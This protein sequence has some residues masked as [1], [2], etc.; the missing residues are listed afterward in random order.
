M[1]VCMKQLQ[2]AQRF[3]SGIREL[4]TYANFVEKQAAGV[5]KSLEKMS[6]VSPGEA[7]GI[8]GAIDPQVW[9][10]SHVEGFR[11]LLASKTKAVVADNGTDRD[12]LLFD[13][14]A[15]AAK[16]T[17]R[18]ATEGSKATIIALAYWTQLCQGMTAKEKYNL[19]LQKKPVV[20]KY[21][22]VPPSSTTILELPV[23]WKDLPSEVAQSVFP[24]GKPM[25]RKEFAADVMQFV[26]NMPLRKDHKLLQGEADIAAGSLSSGSASSG[27]SVDAICKVVEACSRGMQN[28]G[29]QQVL[30]LSSPVTCPVPAQ[31]E[32][33]AVEDGLVEEKTPTGCLPKKP[34]QDEQKD[35]EMSVEQQLEALQ[36]NARLLEE[37]ALKRPAS[38]KGLKRPAAAIGTV[39]Y[40]AICASSGAEEGTA[41]AQA[42]FPQRMSEVSAEVVVYA[43][44]LGRAMAP[45][46]KTE[47]TPREGDGS[48][49]SYIT[50]EEATWPEPAAEPPTRGG[51][52]RMTASKSKAVKKEKDERSSSDRGLRARPR[53][54][55]SPFSP[56]R[57]SSPRRARREGRSRDRS[58]K[59]ARSVAPEAARSPKRTRSVAAADARSPKRARSELPAAAPRSALD[60]PLS[61]YGKDFGKA[62]DLSLLPRGSGTDCPRICIEPAPVVQRVLHSLPAV[63]ERREGETN[64]EKGPAEPWPEEEVV[65]ARSARHRQ[66]REEAEFDEAMGPRREKIPTKEKSPGKEKKK[67]K[68]RRRRHRKPSPTPEVERPR[69]RKPPSDEDDEDAGHRKRRRDDKVWIQVPR[70]SLMAH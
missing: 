6:A 52:G 29:T 23:S 42:P 58:S 50:D 28:A 57:E 19:Y 64:E 54:L 9:S 49:Y 40:A 25:E 34:V 60:M 13:L 26:R 5:K 18:V 8:L 12:Q 59:R 41:D 63:A 46:G 48:E 35:P 56:P 10:P 38:K 65:P 27:L 66:A 61:E 20:T 2:A 22:S 39:A 70:S 43:K 17:L 68:K 21:L 3:L 45:K 7:A 53:D 15:H 44:L 30:S 14:C 1:A 69:R 51:P 31:K 4:A 24:T 47:E 11:L 32:L 16:L 36:G 33:L 37:A 55:P 62:S 67:D